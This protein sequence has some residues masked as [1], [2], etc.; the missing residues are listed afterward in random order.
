[1]QASLLQSNAEAM[2][3]FHTLPGME[4]GLLVLSLSFCF[5]FFIVPLLFLLS[6]LHLSTGS[7]EN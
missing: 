1:M 5:A 3:Q 6:C 7:L 4:A 2:L